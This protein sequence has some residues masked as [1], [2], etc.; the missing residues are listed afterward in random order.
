MHFR[1]KPRRNPG[2]QSQ[3][4]S[5][6]RTAVY[7]GKSFRK[8]RSQFNDRL[9]TNVEAFMDEAPYPKWLQTRR[10]NLYDLA[11]RNIND[12]DDPHWDFAYALYDEI[13]E[14][15]RD[16]RTPTL[17]SAIELEELQKEIQYLS[18]FW[19][20]ISRDWASGKLRYR[21]IKKI[22]D[23]DQRV[24]RY[25]PYLSIALYVQNRQKGDIRNHRLYRLLG[26]YFRG[27]DAEQ[28]RK[29]AQKE[30]VER[31]SARKAAP[32]SP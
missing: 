31:R 16:G 22:A 12:V 14:C 10:G 21:D 15:P 26:K 27:D 32:A 28:R 8:W 29:S 19:V 7:L 18:Y 3:H 11:I 17:L 20:D 13:I 24:L 6:N 9:P 5:V 1:F 23:I 4:R 30:R 25:L 2:S